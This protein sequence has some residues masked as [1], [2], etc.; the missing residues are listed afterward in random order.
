MDL[1]VDTLTGRTSEKYVFLCLNSGKYILLL[2]RENYL[3]LLRGWI[4]I[5]SIGRVGQIRSF[6]SMVII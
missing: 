4:G 2:F 6:A 5:R 3:L 1:R